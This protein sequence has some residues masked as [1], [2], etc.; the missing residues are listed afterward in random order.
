MESTEELRDA[1]LALERENSRLQIE[2][3]R[4]RLL[5]N[6]V[7]RLL[8]HDASDP[9][10]SIFP[11][12]H[13]AFDFSDVVVLNEM[14]NGDRLVCSVAE[15]PHLLDSEWQTGRFLE[16]VL[17][18]RVATM[19]TNEQLQVWTDLPSSILSPRQP[20]STFL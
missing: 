7:E 10:A 15:P 11:A 19:I 1:L 3:D 6:A 2:S 5:I 12:L 16:R 18:G 14:G 13:K 9:F 17:S 8:V 20:R 4:S